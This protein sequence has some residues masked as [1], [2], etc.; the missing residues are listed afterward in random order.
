MAVLV[1]LRELN[2][3]TWASIRIDDGAS[4]DTDDDGQLIV[5]GPPRPDGPPQRSAFGTQVQP[6]ST[7]MLALFATGTW[8][9]ARWD[10]E[11]DGDGDTVATTG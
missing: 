10:G 11:G 8:L 6:T 2:R 7:R 5:W 4:W 1:Q 9:Y 3:S